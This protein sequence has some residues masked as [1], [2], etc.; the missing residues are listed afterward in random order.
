MTGSSGP[1]TAGRPRQRRRGAE[2]RP[3]RQ[4]RRPPGTGHVT[5]QRRATRTYSTQY[6]TSRAESIRPHA[7]PLWEENGKHKRKHFS[8]WT[9]SLKRWNTR[10]TSHTP[11]PRLLKRHPHV[12][13]WQKKQTHG[14]EDPETGTDFFFQKKQEIR[15]D[16]NSGNNLKRKTLSPK[17]R[18]DGRRGRA[19]PC[20]DPS[21]DRS[22]YRRS[23]G[24]SLPR[25]TG[26]SL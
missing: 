15:I 17:G 4:P 24:P 8:R 11:A 9:F 18:L 26:I 2:R 6:R 19:A 5:K 23:L 20:C 25:S 1:P 22:L 13:R 12:S 21:A 16:L 3:T 14:I 7:K 10:P